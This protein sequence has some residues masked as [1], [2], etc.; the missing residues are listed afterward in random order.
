GGF[1]YASTLRRADIHVVG[2]TRAE[3]ITAIEERAPPWNVRIKRR[4]LAAM[5]TALLLASAALLA[6]LLL[7]ERTDLPLEIDDAFCRAGVYHVLAVSG[8]NVA[9]LASAVFATLSFVGAPRRFIAVV[10]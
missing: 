5:S 9:L 4:A 3:R 8:F 1:D 2:T 10:A 6:G 7:G